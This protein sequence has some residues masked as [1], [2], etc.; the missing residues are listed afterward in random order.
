MVLSMSFVNDADME[1]LH[2]IVRCG[3]RSGF[4]KDYSRNYL[5]D[6]IHKRAVSLFNNIMKYDAHVLHDFLPSEKNS[7]YSLHERKH[8]LQLP[9]MKLPF[10]EQNYLLRMLYI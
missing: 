7:K 5:E 2:K 8:N 3:W 6:I 9:V 10:D 1:H 4:I